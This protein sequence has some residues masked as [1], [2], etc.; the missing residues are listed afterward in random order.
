MILK[1]DSTAMAACLDDGALDFAFIDASKSP[2]KYEADVLAWLPK[3]KRGGF[4]SGHD[5]SWDG[6]EAV[7]HRHFG[8]GYERNAKRDAWWVR[9]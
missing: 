5:L 9:L 7:V 2:G 6:I 1:G 4:I 8:T 3:V